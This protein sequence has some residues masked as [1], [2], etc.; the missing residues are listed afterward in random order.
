MAIK[1]KPRLPSPSI[2]ELAEASKDAAKAYNKHTSGDLAKAV[3]N[4]TEA[5]AKMPLPSLGSRPRGRPS[6][7]KDIVTIRLDADV[8]SKFKATGKGWQARI[9]DA[10]RKVLDL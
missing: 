8:V 2:K 5:A 9:N 4:L 7:G 3:S 6:S 10:L 1:L